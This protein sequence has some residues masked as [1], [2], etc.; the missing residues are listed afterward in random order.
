[1][2][3]A[4]VDKKYDLLDR[5][6][7]FEGQPVGHN[8]FVRRGCKVRFVTGPK[9]K[10]DNFSVCQLHLSLLDPNLNSTAISILNSLNSEGFQLKA[11]EGKHEATHLVCKDDSMYTWTRKE[12]T[13]RTCRKKCDLCNPR[14]LVPGVHT[15]LLDGA[16]PFSPTFH[17]PSVSNPAIEMNKS[18]TRSRNNSATVAS[19]SN[20]EA[21]GSDERTVSVESVI[22]VVKKSA[23]QNKKKLNISCNPRLILQK[24]RFKTSLKPR[25]STNS[26]RNLSEQLALDRVAQ[27]LT[28]PRSVLVSEQDIEINAS[29]SSFSTTRPPSPQQVSTNQSNNKDDSAIPPWITQ[30][31]TKTLGL[32]F[33]KI[34]AK[35]IAV[36][37]E[38]QVIDFKLDQ[39][40]L[41]EQNREAERKYRDFKEWSAKTAAK[42]KESF[43]M[44][45]ATLREEAMGHLDRVD[46]IYQ[47][48]DLDLALTKED[49]SELA[50]VKGK[51]KRFFDEDFMNVDLDMVMDSE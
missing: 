44:A 2:Y 26:K 12:W 43:E 21:E 50:C 6:A 34:G 11:E 31:S 17:K 48:K 51:L 49:K 13:M 5:L 22:K 8:D 23:V 18:P 28:T 15:P 46:G 14:D 29:D 24:S 20:S 16:D 41:E 35:R 47:H 45:K 7:S 10:E 1:M 38:R 37:A 3:E 4:M 9:Q 40:I 27:S 25:T 39:E 30:K 36:K 33:I 32:V 42:R 19:N